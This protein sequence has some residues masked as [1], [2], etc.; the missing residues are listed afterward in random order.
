MQRM[1]HAGVRTAAPG[2]CVALLHREL[3]DR[4][5]GTTSG[6]NSSK[7]VEMQMEALLTAL[8]APSKSDGSHSLCSTG[9]EAIYR[10]DVSQKKNED[11][12]I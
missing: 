7:K 3:K 2:D 5:Q 1:S 10:G 11:S 4:S 12:R 9:V 6:G 8:K